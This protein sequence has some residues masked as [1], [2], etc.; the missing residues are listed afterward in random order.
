MMTT[1]VNCACGISPP[2]ASDVLRRSTARGPTTAWQYG[3]TLSSV[4]MNARQFGH[5]RRLSTDTDLRLYCNVRDSGG[6]P[7]LWPWANSSSVLHIY[8]DK[9][10]LC[11]V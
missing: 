3:Q 2:N 7:A 8:L 9:Y 10:I 6:S 5:M 11:G 4:V 1:V